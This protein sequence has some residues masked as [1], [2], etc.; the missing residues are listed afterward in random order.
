[1]R[2]GRARRILVTVAVAAFAVGTLAGP[3]LAGKPT[4]G[5]TST[6]GS[7]SVTPN[8]VAVGAN[9]T[10]SGSKLG[11]G[12]FVNFHVTDAGG[13]TVFNRQSDSSGNAS[14]TWHSYY[15]GTSSV[16]IDDVSGRKAVTVAR[17]SFSV[18]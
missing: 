12:R 4:G 16:R 1:M 10:I 8:P 7:C 13:T 14:V 17:C 3:A 2:E 5:S 15:R 11:A 18:V 9:Y 6:T